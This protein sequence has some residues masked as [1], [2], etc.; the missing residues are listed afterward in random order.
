MRR[1]LITGAAG[2]IG[3]CLRE[4]LRPRVDELVLT[5]AQA[6]EPTG[7]ERFVRADLGDRDAVI[8]AAVGADAVIHLGAIPTEASFDELLGPNL[9]G[10]FNV[11]EAARQGG[12]KRIVFASSNHATGFYPVEQRLSGQDARHWAACTPTSSAST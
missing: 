1:V 8:R 10:T 3:S 5:D 11:F 4:G 6:L 9:I 2:A 7:Q 12:A